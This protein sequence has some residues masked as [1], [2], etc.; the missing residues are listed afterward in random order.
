MDDSP[1]PLAPGTLLANRF[2]LGQ[3]LGRG[4]FGIAYLAGDSERKDE[5]VVKELAPTGSQRMQDGVLKLAPDGSPTAQRLR[6]RF[7]EEARLLAKLDLAG[8]LPVRAAFHEN[9]TAYFASAYLADSTTLDRLI[10][11]EGRLDTAGALDI[12][13][14]LV[15]TLAG[16]HRAGILHR[17]IKPSNILIDPKGKTYL[18]DFGAAREWHADTETSHTVL[19]T[20]GYA[21]IEQL[22]ERAQRGPATDLYA[23]CATAYH[24][25]VGEPPPRATDRA[26]GAPL[27]SLRRLRP[28]IE[29]AVAEAIERGL[30]LRYVDRPQTVADL[31]RLMS[32]TP[33]QGQAVD[34]IEQF[35]ERAFRLQ[36]FSF[37]K[38]QCP[39]CGGL[40]ESPKPLR[41]GVCPVCSEGVIHLRRLADRLCPVCRAGVLRARANDRPLLFCPVCRTGILAKRRKSLLGKEVVL[42]CRLCESV[43]ETDGTG[44]S[45]RSTGARESE[46]VVGRPLSPAQWRTASGRSS[47]VWL[48]DGCEAQLDLQHDGRL[49]LVTPTGKRP[50]TSLYPEEWA[51]VAAGLDPGAGN[52][53]CDACGADYFLEGE[54]VTLLG[55]HRDPHAFAAHHAGRLLTL[56]D[57]QW[58]G[59][60]KES[61]QPG[62][63]CA[64]CGT[65]FDDQP[66]GL[67]LVHTPS[68]AL[69]RRASEVF[70]LRDWC[71]LSQGLPTSS[72]EDAFQMAF[73][74][75][76]V[77]AYE[78][79]RIP[80]DT[81]AKP[82]ELWRSPATRLAFDDDAWIE[83]GTGQLAVL[84]SVVT[85]GGLIR[86]AKLPMGDV[87]E[88]WAEEDRLVVHLCDDT[89]TA[90]Q[91]PD[92]ELSL[93]LKS[94]RRTV[95]LN[96]ACLA[97]RIRR[98]LPNRR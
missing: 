89:Q 84:S 70:D 82:D 61:P 47:D 11:Q 59:V 7:L 80:F 18:I 65:E 10:R 78:Q 37:A 58:L 35:D 51:R 6:Q 45:L 38:R 3:V 93:S 91:V 5:C 54:R 24:M 87:A 41:R 94:G 66:D 53:E 68:A 27:P 67:R 36:R 28:D 85:F 60:G 31:Q 72:Q 96:A 49:L 57:I 32:T 19:F 21:P 8:V 52:A 26:A 76:I 39:A 48:C 83:D 4:G 33:E 73:D 74:E 25:L 40:L 30:S 12:L 16:V 55:A 97:E 9:G 1:E 23:L 2:E 44:L 69:A 92:V 71:R 79:G 17:D 64:A 43:L 42:T 90:F 15:E 88:V 95:R 98:V 46:L 63:V 56:S 86:K 77:D 50:W 75:A 20:P 13:F 29:P 34:P 62:H 81:R 14:Q 22:A